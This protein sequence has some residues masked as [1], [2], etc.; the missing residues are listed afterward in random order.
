M[1]DAVIF[2][3]RIV[4]T[5]LNEELFSCAVDFVQPDVSRS[6]SKT[7]NGRIFVVREGGREGGGERER[8]RER[9]GGGGGGG[10]GRGRGR[11]RLHT[12]LSSCLDQLHGTLMIYKPL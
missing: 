2:S 9:E 12:P 1:V 10:R 5:V 6:N 8:E 4:V 3:K 11:E 7:G